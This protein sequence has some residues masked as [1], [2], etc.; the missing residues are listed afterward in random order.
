MGERGGGGM[1]LEG[2][3]YGERRIGGSEGAHVTNSLLD[4]QNPG[5]NSRNS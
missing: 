1:G 4:V 2:C 3:W 5:F